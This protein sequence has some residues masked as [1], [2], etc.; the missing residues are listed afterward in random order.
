V[1][2]WNDEVKNRPLVNIHRRT[3]D[4]TWRQVIRHF[5]GDA[6]LLLG[7][8]HDTLHMQAQEDRAWKPDSPSARADDAP[9]YEPGPDEGSAP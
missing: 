1:G 4:D 2:R 8:N 6:E 3:L 7:P 5:G 9:H